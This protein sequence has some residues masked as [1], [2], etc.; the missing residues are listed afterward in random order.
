MNKWLLYGSVFIFSSIGGYI[1]SLWHAGFLSASGIIGGIV[2]TAAGIWIAF[3]IN[4]Y[5]DF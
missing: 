5:V 3:Q 2:G 4:N 1:P